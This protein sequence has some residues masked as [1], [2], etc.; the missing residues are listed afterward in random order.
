MRL[1]ALAV[2][3]ARQ[4]QRQLSSSASEAG[5]A[6]GHYLWHYA[7]VCAVLSVAT[8]TVAGTGTGAARKAGVG[9]DDEWCLD[10]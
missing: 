8:T 3:V 2:D 10:D 6:L 4:E 1:N 9:G 7:R 5:S